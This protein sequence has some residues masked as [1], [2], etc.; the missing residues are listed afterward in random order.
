MA[1]SENNKSYLQEIVRMGETD[2]PAIVYAK[3]RADGYVAKV[4]GKTAG[5]GRTVVTATEAGKRVVA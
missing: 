5:R 4:E 1:L 3:L 2:I